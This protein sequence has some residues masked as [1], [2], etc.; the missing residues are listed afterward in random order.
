MTPTPRENRAPTTWSRLALALV[1]GVAVTACQGTVA[2]E[3]DP[4]PG[5][6]SRGAV[7]RDAA[8]TSVVTLA[9]A[10]D[11]HFQLHLA[12]LLEHPRAGLGRIDEALSAADVTMV[13]LES[14][15]TERGTPDPKEREVRDRRYWYRASPAALDVL[16]AAGVDVVTMANN[17]AAD[18]GSVGLRDSLQ[19]ASDSPVAVVGIGRD[20]REAFTPYRT[21]VHGTDIAFLAADGSPREG[22]ST[23]W[24][25]GPSSPGIAAARSARPRALLAAVREA[26]RHDDVVVVYLHWGREYQRCPTALQRR[27]AEALA[28]AGADVV[29]GSHAHVL[30]G[31]GW[32]G[33]TYIGYGLGNFVWYHDRE[34][35][36]GV[37]R[38]QIEDGRVVSDD[39]VPARLHRD[40]L[41][42]PRVGR[43]RAHAVAGWRRLRACADLA[44]RPASSATTSV[45]ADGYT[46][47]VRP[48]GPALAAR[49]SPSHDGACPLDLKD[50]RHLRLSHVGFDGRRHVGELV[51]AARHAYDVVG[52]FERLYAARWPIRRMRLVDEY[53]AADARSMAAD[54]TSAYDCRRVDGT[55]RWSAHAFGAAIDINP[56]ENPY[57]T[58]GAILPPAGRRFAGIDRSRRAPALRGAIRADDVVVRAF[59]AIGWAWGGSWSEPD[60]QHFSARGRSGTAPDRGRPRPHGQ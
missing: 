32:S 12:R 25:A 27:T 31:A 21:T 24:A 3:P 47:T 44:P 15:V 23:T 22:G 40:G 48:I 2:P 46:A 55:S 1:V 49:M 7:G 39:W 28:V 5:P 10:G 56:V 38:L 26:S 36:T 50:L 54:N 34:P 9:F 13:N 4:A 43:D 53:G 11:V 59:A 52:V 33:D 14:A 58:G 18:Y 8:P 41:P 6:A 29:V 42:V 19:A 45:P 57:L 30:L 60:Y 51:V 37:L 16:G 20:R 35:A 17:H